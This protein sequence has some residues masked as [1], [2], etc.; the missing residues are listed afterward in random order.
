MTDPG[1]SRAAAL[2]TVAEMARADSIAIARGTPGIDLMERAGLGV[3]E[4]IC[5][6]WQPRPVVVLAGPGNNGGDGFVAGRILAERG[7]P[8][9]IALLGER[10]A[11]K[12][13]AA[14]VA[15]RWDEPVVPL[16]PEA[17]SGAGLVVDA[18]FGAGLSRPVDGPA[19]VT[20]AAADA[21]RAAAPIVAV[22][23]PSGVH[24]D[25]GSVL[26][27]AAQATLTVTFFRRK[28]G[29]FLLPGRRLCGETQVVDIGIPADV[30]DE[31]RPSHFANGPDLW[32]A[33]YPW[34]REEGHKYDRGHAVAVSG[35][36][37]STGACR[38]AA[39]AALRVGSG[40]VTVASPP[41]AL[42]VNASHLTAVMVR[43]VDGATGLQGLLADRR[44]NAVLVGPGNGLGEGTRASALAA[45]DGQ[46]AVVLDAD[47]L[48]V[49]AD[50]PEVLFAAIAQSGRAG[51][52]VVL[53]P[54]EGEF[55]R[56]FPDLRAGAAE[57]LSR[58][59][60]A[61][62]AAARSGAT[63]LLKGPDTI[64]ADP[65]GRV[66]INGRTSPWLATAGSGDVLAGLV[67]GLLAQGMSGWEAAGAAAWIHGDAARA[68][69]PG[70]VAEDL[71]TLVPGALVR[72]ARLSPES[73][74]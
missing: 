46:R 15:A 29:H 8:V 37:S 18:I 14:A 64:I 25:D 41:S 74:K 35:G 65:G 5:A 67:L 31:I 30:L 23:V 44:L 12:G 73:R 71:L 50:D 72:L 66:A 54:H 19:A 42:I 59:E 38:L 3:A 20:L 16:G 62:L 49:F 26:G 69:G 6:R 10:A 2:L 40:L 9:R 39:N 51:A 33:A 70:L 56:L 4:S 55:A 13:D 47:A 63:I 17:L 7:W 36:A 27:F 53:T 68:F 24:G 22:D 52:P 61:R 48:S 60:R 58:P 28:P 21:A 43:S 1:F 11:L 45:L 57:G 32:G 34:P